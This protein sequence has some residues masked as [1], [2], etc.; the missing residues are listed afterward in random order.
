MM[1]GLSSRRSP[2]W[3]SCGALGAAG[4]ADRPMAGARRLDPD[5]GGGTRA[6]EPK[7]ISAPRANFFFGEISGTYC[8]HLLRQNPDVS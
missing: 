6:A 7:S 4:T 3:R 1:G 2:D 8:L 5:P